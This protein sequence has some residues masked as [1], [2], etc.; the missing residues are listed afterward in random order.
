MPEHPQ[1]RDSSSRPARL[2]LARSDVL[3]YG[4]QRRW[5]A[6]GR[7]LWATLILGHYSELCQECGSR[8]RGFHWHAPGPLYQE[9][10]GSAGGLFCPRCFNRKAA[11]A[12]IWVQWTPMV[13]ARRASP[14]SGRKW[15]M[16][17]NWWF[18][19]TRDRLMMGEPD[20]GFRERDDETPQPTWACVRDAL[21]RERQSAT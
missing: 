17:T 4:R 21:R 1:R 6:L 8:Y 3:Y 11:A 16:T 9:L 12:G 20:P 18:D 10:I 19:E 14:A 2:S 7:A 13:V 5:V 15:D